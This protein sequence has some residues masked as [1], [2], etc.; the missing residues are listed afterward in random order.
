MHSSQWQHSAPTSRRVLW[1]C[2]CSPG[3]KPVLLGMAPTQMLMLVMLSCFWDGTC[4]LTQLKQT[5]AI[6]GLAVTG[7][8]GLQVLELDTW[9]ALPGLPLA[10][11]LHHLILRSKH[12]HTLVDKLQELRSLET[13]SLQV[14]NIWL[15][16]CDPCHA[17]LV[18]LAHLPS[19]K[20]LR[21]TDF[22][23]A[24]TKVPEGCQL[25]FCI[26]LHLLDA[27]D[28]RIARLGVAKSAG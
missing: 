10:P 27:L 13:L 17:V 19:L 1:L 2:H 25:H 28:Y 16:P 11:H 7:M 4:Y 22:V 14:R 12:L 20:H 9:D 5:P 3:S 15:E 18:D 24:H 21:Y 23:P 26:N 6:S 8:H